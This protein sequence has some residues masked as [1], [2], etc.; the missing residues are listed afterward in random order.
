[1]LPVNTGR[2]NAGPRR[3]TRTPIGSRNLRPREPVVLPPEDYDQAGGDFYDCEWETPSPPP[4]A[5][6][7]FLA[8]DDDADDLTEAVARAKAKREQARL[9][10]AEARAAQN[11]APAISS[12]SGVVVTHD[13]STTAAEGD[14][15]PGLSDTGS[16]ARGNTAEPEPLSPEE[17]GLS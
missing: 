12:G 4:S 2:R 1:M 16:N 3:G 7:E 5:P 11:N 14:E 9:A 6:N 10:E 15:Q 13:A 8:D 17:V